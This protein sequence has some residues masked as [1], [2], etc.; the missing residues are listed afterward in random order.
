MNLLHNFFRMSS[1]PASPEIV[2]LPPRVQTGPATA[3]PFAGKTPG[4]LSKSASAPCESLAADK[5]SE[6]VK[7][8][9]RQY[10]KDLLILS[11]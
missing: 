11:D 3:T 1:T 4:I 10:G 9:V 8:I 6:A 5:P 2:Q 7:E